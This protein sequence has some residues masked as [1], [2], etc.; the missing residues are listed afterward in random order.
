M[1]LS[2]TWMLIHLTR[3]INRKRVTMEE[4]S[5]NPEKENYDFILRWTGV[6]LLFVLLSLLIF[7]SHTMEIFKESFLL[8]LLIG[9]LLWNLLGVSSYLHWPFREGKIAK[10]ME[11]FCV[12]LVFFA[13]TTS[14]FLF[15]PMLVTRINKAFEAVTKQLDGTQYYYDERNKLVK[16]FPVEP[17]APFTPSPDAKPIFFAR[18]NIAKDATIEIKDIKVLSYDPDQYKGAIIA[19]NENWCDDNSDG[20][21][22]LGRK[23][24][25]EIHAGQPILNSE[26]DPPFKQ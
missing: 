6:Q 13:P 18:N 5:T 20:K 24:K 10:R 3:T 26:I 4:I 7:P 19:T 16:V 25:N 12:L 22:I 9:A 11:N 1:N 17:S 2:Y 14:V 21:T 8:N 23:V 15:G